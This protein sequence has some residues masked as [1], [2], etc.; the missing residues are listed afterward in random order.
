[1]TFKFPAQYSKHS[2]PDVIGT[3]HFTLD[4]DE[5]RI[6]E[7]GELMK[8]KKGTEFMVTME[9]VISDDKDKVDK[10]LIQETPQQILTRFRK[11]FHSL[12]S[13]VADMKRKTPE[14]IKEIIKKRL[15]REKKIENSTKEMSI[16]LLSLEIDNLEKLLN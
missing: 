7:V 15:I 8:T 1:M 2:G 13:E 12:M 3:H 5:T 14:E 11:R 4:V 9:S 16:D 6:N 10:D